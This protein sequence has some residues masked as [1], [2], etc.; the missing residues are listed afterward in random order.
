[1][2]DGM[3]HGPISHTISHQPLAISHGQRRRHSS[4]TP[5]R[6]N[7]SGGSSVERALE[8]CPLVASHRNSG[9]ID[10]RSLALIETPAPS[11]NDGCVRL[12]PRLSD[13][14]CTGR[15]PG[16]GT[17]ERGGEVSVEGRNPPPA[18]AK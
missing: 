10:S 11:S 3:V 12:Q 14:P 16:P 17:I 1:M 2:A 18:P 6:R 8:S 15:P 5:P 9:R 13:G 7:S 4:V